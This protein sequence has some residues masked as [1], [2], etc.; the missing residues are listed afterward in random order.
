MN[1]IVIAIMDIVRPTNISCLLSYLDAK[2]PTNPPNIDHGKDHIIF[3]K[4]TWKG[5]SVSLYIMIIIKTICI[6]NPIDE[7]K[8]PIDSFIKFE[9]K[10]K[11]LLFNKVK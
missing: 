6:Q 1:N 11:L 8:P 9:L 3:A 4:V 7:A 2:V 10:S 5:D